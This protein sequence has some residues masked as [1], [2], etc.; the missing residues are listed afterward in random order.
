MAAIVLSFSEGAISLLGLP[1]LAA[2]GGVLYRLQVSAFFRG[3][4]FILSFFSLFGDL[5]FDDGPE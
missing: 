4:S 1:V 5:R 3:D 2:L